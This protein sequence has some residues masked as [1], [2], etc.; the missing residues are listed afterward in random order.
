MLHIFKN[1]TDIP[2]TLW[3]NN[4]FKFS[5]IR[6]LSLKK[7]VQ[8]WLVFSMVRALSHALKGIGAP[9]QGSYPGFRFDPQ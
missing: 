6:K 1:K 7:Q 9:S 4:R 3:E 8:H 5:Y 2:L